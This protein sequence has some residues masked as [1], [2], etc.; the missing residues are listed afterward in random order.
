MR[1][2]NKVI[3]AAATAAVAATLA[4][5]PAWA[6][7]VPPVFSNNQSGVVAQ[8]GTYKYVQTVFT[9][10][11]VTP[12][13]GQT[14]V[15][16]YLSDA[17]QS[18]VLSLGPVGG[19]AAESASL[20]EENPTPG[21]PPG[22]TTGYTDNTDTYTY[23]PGDKVELSVGY[24]QSSGQ[25]TYTVTNLTNDIVP[26]FSGQF[27]DLSQQFTQAFAGAL[28]SGDVYAT[29]TAFTQPSAK[30]E[31]MQGSH[32]LITDINGVNV[33][34]AV[35]ER[36]AAGGNKLGVKLTQVSTGTAGKNFTVYLLP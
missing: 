33:T 35:K 7:S 19:G 21:L 25:V 11:L 30:T 22:Y 17:D 3:A 1:N 27:T 8:G 26:V 10:P 29:P 28:F 20:T 9:V 5:G 34:S 15:A 36:T 24:D 32:T 18:V 2:A 12:P 14:S 16:V 31:L 6:S 4:A 13:N 23:A